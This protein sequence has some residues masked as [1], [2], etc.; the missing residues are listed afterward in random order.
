MFNSFGKK[1]LKFK[2]VNL[3]QRET[4]YF[5]TADT[6]YPQTREGHVFI[7]CWSMA[8]CSFYCSTGWLRSRVLYTCSPLWLVDGDAL[9]IKSRLHEAWGRRH[10]PHYRYHTD[11]RIYNDIKSLRH[12][13]LHQLQIHFNL[14]KH[15]FIIVIRLSIPPGIDTGNSS[16]N[17]MYY[18]NWWWTQSEIILMSVDICFYSNYVKGS[19]KKQRYQTSVQPAYGLFKTLCLKCDKLVNQSLI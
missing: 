18:Q 3:L 2:S 12:N 10:A 11:T 19:P 4:S 14:F 15:E 7:Y 5:D 1:L 17:S 9:V 13:Q 8:K 6:S 16:K